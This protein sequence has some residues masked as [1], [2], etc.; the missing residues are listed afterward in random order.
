MFAIIVSLTYSGIKLRFENDHFWLKKP[1]KV[2]VLFKQ[3]KNN[4]TTTLLSN[5][6]L[7]ASAFSDTLVSKAIFFFKFSHDTHHLT[8]KNDH[9]SLKFTS[10]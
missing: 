2:N 3:I 4:N 9:F 5:V 10:T 6:V 7:V 8:A 1:S